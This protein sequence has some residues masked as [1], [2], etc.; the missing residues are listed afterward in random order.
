MSLT[1]PQIQPLV[2]EALALLNAGKPGA[3][4]KLGRDLWC[5]AGEFPECYDLLD[6][7]YGAL[8]REPLR[9]MLV[10]ARAWRAYCDAGRPT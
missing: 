7:A 1:R 4:L 10:E 8:G 5:W 9:H 2:A 6:A 3:A